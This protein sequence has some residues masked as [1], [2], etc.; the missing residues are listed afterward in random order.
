MFYHLLPSR[1]GS[2]SKR[3]F[4]KITAINFFKNTKVVTKLNLTKKITQLIICSFM[5][6][7]SP[8]YEISVDEIGNVI[9]EILEIFEV[10]LFVQIYSLLISKL[11]DP[12][13]C[14]FLQILIYLLFE[15]FEQLFLD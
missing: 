9:Q 2:F 3:Q 13:N 12:I 7:N 14:N 6:C 8:Y 10:R 4:S 15:S 5:Q 11:S 1:D